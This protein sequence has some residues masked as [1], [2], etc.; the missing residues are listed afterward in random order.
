MQCTTHST[1]T[2]IEGHLDKQ[3][4]LLVAQIVV[5]DAPSGVSKAKTAQLVLFLFLSVI[6][7]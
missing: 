5:T 3:E 4:A 6:D 2:Q 7:V 1:R